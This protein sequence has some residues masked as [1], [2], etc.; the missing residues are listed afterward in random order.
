M[1]YIL[2]NH[3]SQDAE[4]ARYLAADLERQ[5]LAVRVSSEASP[6]DGLLGQAVAVIEVLSPASL[7][8]V[9]DHAGRASAYGRPIYVVRLAPDVGAGPAS[10]QQ[11][12]LWTDAFGP[13]AQ[14]NVGALAAELRRLQGGGLHPGA[15]PAPHAPR[16]RT[17][18]AV[19]ILLGVVGLAA[20]GVGVWQLVESGVFD[21]SSSSSSA[22]SSKLDV[23][24]SDPLSTTW[25]V[26]FIAGGLTY[27]G[28][29]EPVM[30]SGPL[31]VIYYHPQ[32]GPVRVIQDCTMTGSQSFQVTCRNPRVLSGN[33]T[34]DPDNF[35]LTRFS[36]TELRGTFSSVNT[37]GPG[38][39]FRKGSDPRFAEAIWNSAGVPAQQSQASSLPPASTA[40]AA[41]GDLASQLRVAADVQRRQLP[42]RNGPATITAVDAIGT[43]LHLYITIS[44]DL[45]AAQWSAMERS[46]RANICQGS[47]ADMVRQGASV[48]YHMLD[49]AEE[50]RTVTV[51]SC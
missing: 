33:V 5:G 36:D 18:P 19:P 44:R 25:R 32:E 10:L 20:I 27:E 24:I 49:S 39:T 8:Y 46:M 30:G 11:A 42:I 13:Q 51:S 2:L 14:Q 29:F 41:G 50:Q 9:G 48:T 15:A 3:H 35:Q 26:T 28:Q 21:G 43:T 34:Y 22:S 38:A 37:S 12:R 31:K 4:T 1:N 7:N 17:N 6:D 16:S 45:G 40:P 23:S 47:S